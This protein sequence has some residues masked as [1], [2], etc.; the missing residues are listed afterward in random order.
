MYLL[1]KIRNEGNIIFPIE[2]DEISNY[3]EYIE[4]FLGKEIDLEEYK[5]LE[6]NLALD[7][8]VRGQECK[9]S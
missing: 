9:I 7:R 6:D 3:E 2:K 8:E 1:L 4:N 5:I